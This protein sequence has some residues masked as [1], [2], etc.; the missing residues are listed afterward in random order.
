V[1]NPPREILYP[2]PAVPM[3]SCKTP[4]MEQLGRIDTFQEYAAPQ[5]GRPQFDRTMQHIGGKEQT[6][7][8]EVVSDEERYKH[9]Q[10]TLNEKIGKHMFLEYAIRNDREIPVLPPVT[11]AEVRESRAEAV[12]VRGEKNQSV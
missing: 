11:M 2:V 6:Y 7:F 5:K 10:D 1:S 9:V 4:D 12:K 3:A 8:V